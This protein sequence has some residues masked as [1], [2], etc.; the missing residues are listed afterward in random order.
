MSNSN[1]ESLKREALAK[2]AIQESVTVV[3]GQ[4]DGDSD[5]LR[6][7]LVELYLDGVTLLISG[8]RVLLP[9]QV[10][11]LQNFDALIKSRSTIWNEADF[12]LWADDFEEGFLR[13]TGI[14]GGE[15][16]EWQRKKTPWGN[17]YENRPLIVD[18]SLPDRKYKLAV[19][20]EGRQ[21]RTPLIFTGSYNEIAAQIINWWH[22]KTG[23]SSTG[24]GRNSDIK[25]LSGHPKVY[26]YFQEERKDSGERPKEGE[27][28]FRLMGETDSSISVPYLKK[29]ATKIEAI[30]GKREGYYWEKGK[31]YANYNHWELGYKLQL[32]S[33]SPSQ[34]EILIKNIL[35]IQGHTFDPARMTFSQNQGESRA[36]PKSPG[37]KRIL[38][39]D[40]DLPKR[41]PECRARFRSASVEIG[42]LKQKIVIFSTDK[43]TPTDS[44]FK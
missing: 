11:L 23:E 14:K 40:V 12:K 24:Q 37:K 19:F 17:P 5:T 4:A 44:R 28:T 6:F 43:N 38:G 36:F 3:K 16:V 2:I 21:Q 18:K 7:G 27:I 30:F 31:R 26:L 29:I 10:S 1:L 33:P 32:L 9:L 42:G 15:F 22:Q 39:E 25:M 13:L 20:Y 8:A 34:G 41:R 35:A